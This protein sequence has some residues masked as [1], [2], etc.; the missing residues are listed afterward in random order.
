MDGASPERSADLAEPT[1]GLCTGNCSAEGAAG[2]AGAPTGWI[3]ATDDADTPAPEAP[4]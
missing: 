3:G 2:N 4:G 1:A